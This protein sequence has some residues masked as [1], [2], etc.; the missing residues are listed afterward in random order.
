MNMQGCTRAALPAW[1]FSV[2]YPLALLQDQL[3]QRCLA[4]VQEWESAAANMQ[5]NRAKYLWTAPNQ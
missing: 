5:A 2:T 1:P 3:I 4:K